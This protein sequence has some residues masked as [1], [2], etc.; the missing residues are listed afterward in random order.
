MLL[1]PACCVKPP[2]GEESVNT[3]AWQ[4]DELQVATCTTVAGGGKKGFLG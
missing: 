1:V 4:V 3:I 2:Q